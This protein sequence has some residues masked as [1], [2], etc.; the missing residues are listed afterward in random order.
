MILF[1]IMP[2]SSFSTLAKVNYGD[3][4]TIISF[5]GTLISKSF[6][7]SVEGCGKYIGSPG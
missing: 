6:R 1:N 4:K 3:L 2:I 5:F 7:S